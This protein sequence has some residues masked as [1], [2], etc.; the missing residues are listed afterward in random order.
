MGFAKQNTLSVRVSRI[1]VFTSLEDFKRVTSSS[2]RLHY[3]YRLKE[4]AIKDNQ[5]ACRNLVVELRQ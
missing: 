3:R 5:G 2:V 1:F 4:F